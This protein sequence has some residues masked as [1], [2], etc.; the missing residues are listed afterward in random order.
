MPAPSKIKHP[1]IRA[2]NQ[3]HEPCLCLTCKNWYTMTL[4]NRPQ[5][6]QKQCNRIKCHTPDDADLMTMGKHI[7]KGNVTQCNIYINN[8]IT[9]DKTPK[10]DTI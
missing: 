5:H 1:E 2:C 6:I 8:E 3:T 7:C 9:L 10:T 4:S